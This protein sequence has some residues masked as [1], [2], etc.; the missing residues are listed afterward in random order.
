[1]N[2]PIK[3]RDR[4]VSIS[5][6]AI[7]TALFTVLQFIPYTFMIGG[8]GG[9]LSLSD[10]LPPLYGIILGPFW[11]GLTLVLGTVVAFLMG[12]PLIFYGLDFLPNLMAVVAVGFLVRG[13]KIPAV[14]VNAVLLAIFLLNPLTLL[15][16]GSIPFA[17]MHIVSLAVLISPLGRMAAEWVRTLDLR[18]ISTGIA[19]LCLIGT[20]ILHLTGNILFEAIQGQ[21]TM[22]IPAAAYP[23]I[24][25][26]VFFVYPVERAILIV[27]GVLVGTPLMWFINNSHILQL[28]EEGSGTGVKPPDQRN[29]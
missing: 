1:M 3:S 27:S 18:K 8:A 25:T 12:R 9:F 15:F 20:M 19:I 17:W 4:L 16:V 10:L 7:F 28:G 2:N 22:S 24:W 23:G 21:L 29:E 13:K 14:A 26:A 11:G 5:M 6:S